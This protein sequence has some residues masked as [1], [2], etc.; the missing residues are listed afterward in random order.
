MNKTWPYW[1]T[2]RD[3]KKNTISET[4]EVDYFKVRVRSASFRIGML[5][6]YQGYFYSSFIQNVKI[7][8]FSVSKYYSNDLRVLHLGSNENLTLS[9]EYSTNLLSESNSD[10]H[11][12]FSR[13]RKL[14]NR[15][16]LNRFHKALNILFLNL[17]FFL[18][19]VIIPWQ[20]TKHL[21]KFL[22]K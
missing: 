2:L 15:L 14:I 11:C 18:L 22:A 12:T 17:F 1:Y 10:I 5:R 21:K 9:S 4:V 8:K 20:N 6:E 3:W 7:A 13:K 16:A 19:K